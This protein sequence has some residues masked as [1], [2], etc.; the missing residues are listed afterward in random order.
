MDDPPV[1]RAADY[2][3]AAR[4]G[5]T[6]RR[7]DRPCSSRALR[8]IASPNTTASATPATSA[9]TSP[10]STSRLGHEGLVNLV[11]AAPE[12]AQRSEKDGRLA[13]APAFAEARGPHGEESRRGRS[14]P[15]ARSCRFRSNAGAEH[16]EAGRR[17]P[18]SQNS[19]ARSSATGAQRRSRA[20]RS[21]AAPCVLFSIFPH[22]SR[23]ETERLKTGA[24]SSRPG[25]RRNSPCARAGTPCPRGS[26]ASA[27]S[28][29]APVRTTS[30]SG[31]RFARKSLPSGASSGF[32]DGEEPVVEPH[33]R[34]D[35][36]GG[37][38][39]VDRA[40]D[41]AAAAPRRPSS[42]GRRSRGSR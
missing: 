4:R 35:G 36:F 25:P 22:E 21:H 18:E 17:R 28:T 34:G 41:L 2:E 5:Q 39:P 11:R 16:R 29:R 42:R 33:F 9:T 23:S 14:T 40:L 1:R 38:H 15:R 24:P 10:I 31:L 12:H 32:C 27:G 6:A 30:D 3:G 8:R 19:K 13:A 7:S 26:A 37:G 20:P